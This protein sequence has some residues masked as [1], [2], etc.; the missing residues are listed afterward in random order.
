MNSTSKN[1]QYIHQIDGLRA[2]AV[3][4]VVIY[5]F[6]PNAIPGGYS[7]VDMFFVISGFLI[8]KSLY[9]EGNIANKG[10]VFDF[11]VRRFFRIYPLYLF[12]LIVFIFVS[13]FIYIPDDLTK[14]AEQSISAILLIPNYYFMSKLDVGYFSTDAKSS[15]FLH[16]WSIGVEIQN[17]IIWGVGLCIISKFT[18]R[19]KILIISMV[20]LFSF[21]YSQYQLSVN[22]LVSFY[23]PLSRVWEFAAGSLCYLMRERKNKSYLFFLIVNAIG[24]GLIASSYFILNDYSPYPGLL[25]APSVLGI[26]LLIVGFTNTSV[27]IDWVLGN[28]ILTIIGKISYSMYLWHWPL[29]VLYQYEYGKISVGIA[30]SL[31]SLVFLVSLITERYIELPF[32]DSSPSKKKRK[33]LKIN[34][35]LLIL[36]AGS[37][38][39]ISTIQLISYNHGYLNLDKNAF[40]KRSDLVNAFTRP[41]YVYDFNCQSINSFSESIFNDDRCVIGNKKNQPQMLIVGDS[42]SAH[43][44]G[45]L[46]QVA[47]NEGLTFRNATQ[48]SCPPMGSGVVAGYTDFKYINAC[49][50]YNDSLRKYAN[51]YDVIF[52][53]ALW[54]K[55]YKNKNFK[56]DFE[57]MIDALSRGGKEVI[58]A[59][60]VPVFGDYDKNCT[61]KKMKNDG[62]NCN[63]RLTEPKPYS[64]ANEYIK[65]I[66]KK[67]RGV[68]TFD[69]SDLICD[70]EGCH[71]SIND[72]PIY[73]DSEHLS[74][75][76]S[77]YLGFFAE[78]NHKT[79][80]FLKQDFFN[81]KRRAPT[82]LHEPSAAELWDSFK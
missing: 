82:P 16:L 51:D 46:S 60:Q 19:I 20:L 44:V 40:D 65:N 64:D 11:Y 75:N 22:N 35:R 32:R 62:L 3:L 21:I 31:F 71:A 27:S 28:P 6:L 39:A 18:L 79:P 38:T 77:A 45:Y 25:A 1:R 15:I 57:K 10:D 7:G 4:G 41:A 8:T 73:Y 12:V 80:F 33:K 72:N 76:G 37:I 26:M 74:M 23:S 56:A 36:M 43:F 69:I 30:I 58:I 2:I 42:N 78:R 63:D 67:Y 47:S 52:I 34:A 61:L 13:C 9:R 24:F 50:Q 81:G 55:Y 49:K 66:S 54:E 17:Y 53:G 5:H 68:H 70:E 59:L 48:S 14:Q 29:V